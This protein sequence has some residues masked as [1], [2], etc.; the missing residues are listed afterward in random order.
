M[1]KKSVPPITQKVYLIKAKHKIM[2]EF[3]KKSK[4]LAFK[5]QCNLKALKKLYKKICKTL[6][7]KIKH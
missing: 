2:H 4:D 1:N 6:Y 5:I 3:Y 7:L